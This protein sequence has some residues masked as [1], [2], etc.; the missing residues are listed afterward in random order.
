MG[1]GLEENREGCALKIP[2]HRSGVAYGWL[3]AAHTPI[4]MT[5]EDP[6]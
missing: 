2:G 4:Q 6:P 5:I 1:D 3:L